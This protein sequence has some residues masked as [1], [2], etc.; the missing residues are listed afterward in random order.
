MWEV[1][2]WGSKNV[3]SGTLGSKKCGKWDFQDAVSPPPPHIR[4][5]EV[6]HSMCFIC[7]PCTLQLLCYNMRIF[8]YVMYRRVLICQKS[9]NMSE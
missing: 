3:G 9:I 1:G 8:K 2:L 5:G 7:T 6:L 4:L